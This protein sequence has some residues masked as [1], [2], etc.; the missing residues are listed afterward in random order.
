[1]LGRAYLAAGTSHAAEALAEFERCLKRRGEA[2]DA[3]IDDMPTLRYLPPAY[4]WLARA[5]ESVGSAVEARKN[6]EQFL[7]LRADA[8]SP[9]PLVVDARRRVSMR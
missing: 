5:Q 9:D 6:Y 4:Y 2:S 1:M 8:D 7:T 3:F